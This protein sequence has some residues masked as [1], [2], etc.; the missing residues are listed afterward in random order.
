MRKYQR[1]HAVLVHRAQHV[2]AQIAQFFLIDH[3]ETA[4]DERLL[5]A[6]LL[7]R[8]FAVHQQ[9]VLDQ[10]FDESGS[11]EARFFEVTAEIESGLARIAWFFA[12]EQL[13]AIIKFANQFAGRIKAQR[14]LFAVGRE[15]GQHERIAASVSG[16]INLFAQL[17]AIVEVGVDPLVQPHQRQWYRLL[18]GRKHNRKGA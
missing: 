13:V 10:L 1:Q 6:V 16:H 17:T 18:G 9:A 8:D 2:A 4:I 7:D 15:P 12:V 14:Q 5:G 3:F 11:A